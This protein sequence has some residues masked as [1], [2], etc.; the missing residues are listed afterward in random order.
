MDFCCRCSA[1]LKY[2][3]ATPSA[4][5]DLLFRNAELAEGHYCWLF[6]LIS[7]A[8][9]L[10]PF[11]IEDFVS[12]PVVNANPSRRLGS[13]CFP[14]GQPFRFQLEFSHRWLAFCH[15]LGL[16]LRRLGCGP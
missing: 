10:S 15:F 16:P 1:V 2:Q 12:L 4:P 5:L 11:L 9:P 7:V 13:S 14:G 8:P 6:G 3:P